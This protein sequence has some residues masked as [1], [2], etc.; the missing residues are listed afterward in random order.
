MASLIY[1]CK[2]RG[3]PI[4]S[5][6]SDY[7]I[8]WRQGIASTRILD[9]RSFS[10]RRKVSSDRLPPFVSYYETYD[11]RSLQQVDYILIRGSAPVAV[12][13]SLVEFELLRTSG[14][15]AIYKKKKA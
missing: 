8:I 13:E 4:Y 11:G 12:R 9:E 2:F 10:L 3:R 15:W 6:F 1:D 7:Y 14:A 5:H